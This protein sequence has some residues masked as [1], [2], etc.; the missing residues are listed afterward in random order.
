MTR[1]SERLLETKTSRASRGGERLLA[2]IK[3]VVAASLGSARG[4]VARAADDW[5]LFAFAVASATE[6]VHEETFLEC[7]WRVAQ[8]AREEQD[9]MTSYTRAFAGAA[10]TKDAF[11]SFAEFLRS[12]TSRGVR[13]MDRL[14]SAVVFRDDHSSPFAVSRDAIDAG[15][16]AVASLLL[17]GLVHP[18]TRRW[19]EVG[20]RD[21]KSAREGKKYDA[22]DADALRVFDPRKFVEG[23]CQSTAAIVLLA[24]RAC[25]APR[26]ATYA[27]E[28]EEVKAEFAVS[29][30]GATRARWCGRGRVRRG[31]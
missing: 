19:F 4:L 10:Y 9:G 7:A 21:A 23:L 30:W 16:H 24:S 18:R 28:T 31:C 3:P 25:L 2:R 20:D 22:E 8:R 15:G 1:E 5:C 26:R 6:T 12:G 14:A 13:A 17:E 11:A 27:Q 29:P